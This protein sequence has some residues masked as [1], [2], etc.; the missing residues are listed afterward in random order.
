[1]GF[2]E[3]IKSLSIIYDLDDKM[4]NTPPAV[5]ISL[6][7]GLLSIGRNFQ[8]LFPGHKT[9]H[10]MYVYCSLKLKY[11]LS[12]ILEHERSRLSDLLIL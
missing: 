6:L 10:L 7:Y 3:N 12:C 4:M 8:W 5:Q 1:M 2:L 9:K 11:A